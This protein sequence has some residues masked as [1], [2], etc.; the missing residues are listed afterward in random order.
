MEHREE[1]VYYFEKL[2][3]SKNLVLHG[4][5]HGGHVLLGRQ[6]A[7]RTGKTELIRIR[8]YILLLF[9]GTSSLTTFKASLMFPVEWGLVLFAERITLSRISCR[10]TPPLLINLPGLFVFQHCHQFCWISNKQLF[11][12]QFIILCHAS[13]PRHP[14]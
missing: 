2:F 3:I 11:N 13:N 1:L 6:V 14:K 10:I 4:L 8:I 5:L 12:F 9:T 7:C